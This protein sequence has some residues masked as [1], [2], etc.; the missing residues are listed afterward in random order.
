[1]RSGRTAGLSRR[2]FLAT[3]AAATILVAVGT[4]LAKK[5]SLSEDQYRDIVGPGPDPLVFTWKGLAVMTLVADRVI[6]PRKDM[7]SI[8]DTM[9]PRR[10]DK[11]LSFGSDKLQADMKLSLGYLEVLPGL[12]GDLRPFSALSPQEQ[13]EFLK[14]M[15]EA[16]GD[17]RAIYIALKFFSGLFY[18][19]D[20]R[21]WDAIGY[22]GPLVDEKLFEAGTRIANIKMGAQ[23]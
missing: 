8:F 22:G 10:I 21:S 4:G 17:N 11:E 14:M 15:G 6:A 18:F 16:G 23:R 1:M 19:T 3:G 7:P 9:T 12:K 13:F 5:L 20:D 2:G